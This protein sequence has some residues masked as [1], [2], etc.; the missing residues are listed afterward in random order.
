M[1]GMFLL[2]SMCC[3]HCRLSVFSVPMY[4]QPTIPELSRVGQLE[5]I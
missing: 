1:A 2:T 5:P 3:T 4:A